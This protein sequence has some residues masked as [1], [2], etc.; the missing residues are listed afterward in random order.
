MSASRMP[1]TSCRRNTTSAA[2]PN[3]YHQLA[4]LR[5]TGCS[6]TS[7]IGAAS[8]NRRSNHSPTCV[9][10]RRTVASFQ[11]DLR[12]ATLLW[13]AHPLRSEEHT[14]ELQSPDHLV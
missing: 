12:S 3:T 14:S 9:I 11:G 13:A 5:G 6:E 2:L 1:V 7:R 8:C 10:R 4:V